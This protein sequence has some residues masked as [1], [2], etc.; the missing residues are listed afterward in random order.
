MFGLGINTFSF[1]A[2]WGLRVGV[3]NHATGILT[4][5][6]SLMAGAS[7]VSL[8]KTIDADCGLS[9][10]NIA[11]GGNSITAVR[12]EFTE[13]ANTDLLRY[14][15]IIWDGSQN[16]YTTTAEY[17]DLMG[18]AIA[19]IPHDRWLIIPPI[20]PYGS[21]YAGSIPEDI[22]Q[23]MEARWPGHVF[24]WSNGLVHSAFAIAQDQF[25]NPPADVFHL[26]QLGANNMSAAIL[27]ELR[28]RGW[29]G[30]QRFHPADL[31][32]LVALYLPT[33]DVS[34][35]ADSS[36]GG[37]TLG[38]VNP[39]VPGEASG[40]AILTFDGNNDYYAGG[41]VH[42]AER[43]IGVGFRKQDSGGRI[44]YGGRSS[45]NARSYIGYGATGTV[46]AVGSASQ[47]VLVP[48]MNNDWQAAVGTHDGATVKLMV[49]GSQVYAEPQSGLTVP[50][51]SAMLGT[52]NNNGSPLAAYHYGD[53]SAA[54]EYDRALSDD[55]MR[56][57]CSW[58]RRQH[59]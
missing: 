16:G 4:G 19:E 55:E 41:P 15:V 17:C 14:P 43:T 36:G 30:T 58:I 32:G 22:W 26:S 39:A 11:V 53:L 34:S 45:T 33:A 13:L 2:G 31:S 44:L 59:S 3:P 25:V 49:N 46:M 23:E 21:A 29:I 56:S 28:A 38:A 40:H 50:G 5:G 54:V 10:N 8:W 52:M 42:G 18:D 20:N 51:V 37:R 9:V 1:V 48:V 27:A 35:V 47:A 24:H 6:D 57:L 7:G 12:S